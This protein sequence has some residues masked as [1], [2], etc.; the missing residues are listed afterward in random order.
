MK[1]AL[2][3]AFC[4]IMMFSGCK[5]D[6]SSA[7]YAYSGTIMGKSAFATTCGGTYWIVID[8]LHQRTTFN[9]VPSGSGVDLSANIFPIRVNL[10]WHY[11]NPNICDEIVIDQ[12]AVAQQ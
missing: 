1:Y 8:S 9:A 2:A 10:N 5:K 6:T 4:A 11:A 7:V 3:A 12:I